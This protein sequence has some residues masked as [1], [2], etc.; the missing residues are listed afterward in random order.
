[1]PVMEPDAVADAVLVAARSPIEA[2]GSC[3]VVQHGKR[4][5]AMEFADVPGPDSRLNVA[6]APHFPDTD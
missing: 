4:A 5:W 6:V 2:T 3:W 1:V